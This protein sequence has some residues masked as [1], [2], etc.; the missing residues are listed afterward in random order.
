[1]YVTLNLNIGI[2]CSTY[3]RS[4]TRSFIRLFLRT[5]NMNSFDSWNEQYSVGANKALSGH[6]NSI[7]LEHYRPM[8]R[9][10]GWTESETVWV[11][12]VRMSNERCASAL[13]FAASQLLSTAVELRPPRD[14]VGTFVFVHRSCPPPAPTR[15]PLALWPPV[16][17]IPATATGCS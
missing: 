1:M 5:L 17:S 3:A 2:S 16:A 8:N 13:V 15:V 6:V 12:R 9:E 7:L 4:C 14:D 10:T 11:V